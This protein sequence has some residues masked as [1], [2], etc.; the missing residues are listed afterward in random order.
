MH[1]VQHS[2]LETAKG[3]TLEDIKAVQLDILRVIVDVCTRYDLKYF[4]VGGT[5]LGA[6]RHRGFIPWDDDIDIAL[7][8][9]D[10]EKLQ[11]I[12]RQQLPSGYR[13]INYQDEW[14]LHHNI[15]KVIDTRTVLIEES[16]RCRQVELGVYVDLFPLDGVPRGKLLREI[17]YH[18]INF[19]KTLLSIPWLDE[20][21]QWPWYKRMLILAAQSLMSERVQATAHECLERL[22]RLHEYRSADQVA[23]HAGLYGKRELMPK[24]WFGEGSTVEFEGLRINAPEEPDRYL[25]QLYG[26]YM[27]LPPEAERRTHHRYVAYPAA[28]E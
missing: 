7:P 12:C 9:Q 17:H 20:A 25:R 14:K 11:E 2:G 6:V 28:C 18:S 3:L 24:A 27:R 23:N 21:K 8:R 4:A 1:T 22:M 10:Y 26:E 19:L 15:S 5:L 16:S 13:F